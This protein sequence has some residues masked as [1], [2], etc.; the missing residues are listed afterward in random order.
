MDNLADCRS[1]RSLWLQRATRPGNGFLG[2]ILNWHREF[3]IVERSPPWQLLDS[4][5]V[6]PHLGNQPKHDGIP[7]T[8]F[9]G[10]LTECRQS[11]GH[12]HQP[13]RFHAQDRTMP[14]CFVIRW[15]IH[16]T[17]CHRIKMDIGEEVL[18]VSLILDDPRLVTT[19]PHGSDHAA[20][21]T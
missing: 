18:D 4:F 12:I 5:S 20:T 7:S 17:G 9:L 13:R 6:P 14:T 16:H 1:Q 21:P 8:C 3:I 11:G 2:G 19:L 10:I 15:I